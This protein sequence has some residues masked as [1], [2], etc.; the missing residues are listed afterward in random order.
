MTQQAMPTA[1]DDRREALDE[2][3]GAMD[4]AIS[5][6]VSRGLLRGLAA[7]VAAAVKGLSSTLG[8][9][10]PAGTGLA[11]SEVDALRAV[12]ADPESPDLAAHAEAAIAA[13]ITAYATL[14]GTAL[15]TAEAAER[16]GVAPS[17]IRAMVSGGELLGVKVRGDLRIPRF[18][19]GDEGLLPNLARVMRALDLGELHPLAVQS[20]FV[21][22]RDQ[23]D[24]LCVRDWLL[25]G[26]PPEP[27]IAM[28]GHAATVP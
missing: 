17:R 28:A 4:T 6:G 25:T 1:E 10:P 15:P 12:G 21:L 18:Q 9:V 19:F 27:V 7:A 14:A 2:I 26:H 13:G 5:E 11:E 23:L 24:H 20:W 3:G 16:A 8:A 22:Q